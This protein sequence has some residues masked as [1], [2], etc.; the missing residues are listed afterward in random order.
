MESGK[1]VIDLKTG[2]NYLETDSLILQWASLIW[3]GCVIDWE[4]GFSKLYL[5]LMDSDMDCIAF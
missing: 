3:N 4:R 5:E 2:V 1:D